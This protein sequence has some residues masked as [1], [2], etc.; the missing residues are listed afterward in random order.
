MGGKMK[1]YLVLLFLVVLIGAIVGFVTIRARAE[2][3]LS[4]LSGRLGVLGVPVRSINVTGQSSYN[5][6]VTIQSTSNNQK[7]SPDDSWYMVLVLREVIFHYR[8]GAK[9]SHYE[10]DVVNT[11]GENIYNISNT[12]NSRDPAQNR[13]LGQSKLDNQQTLTLVRDKLVLG[14]FVMDSSDVRTINAPG[15]TG[16]VLSV[17]IS[18]KDVSEANQYLPNFIASFFRILNAGNSQYGTYI[19]AAHLQLVD[20]SGNVLLEYDRENEGGVEFWSGAP[21]LWDPNHVVEPT[22]SPAPQ[23]PSPIPTATM[24]PTKGFA[25]ATPTPTNIAYPPPT[26]PYPDQT[27]YP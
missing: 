20:Q 18:T 1:K 21:N 13:P 5:V 2:P 19:V 12:L 27:P 23:L 25:L 10:I 11:N 26:T 22:P 8:V 17:K 15:D 24:Q 3:P 9:I 16:Q 6:V 4:D 7:T 14:N